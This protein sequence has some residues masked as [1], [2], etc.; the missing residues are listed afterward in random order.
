LSETELES[1]LLEEAQDGALGPGEVADLSLVD[2][3]PPPTP[4]M[5]LAFYEE[6]MGA[7]EPP[8]P[9]AD[10]PTPTLEET[11]EELAVE[12][13]A[14]FSEPPPPEVSD[15]ADGIL[16]P[17][18]SAMYMEWDVD[19]VLD[20]ADIQEPETVVERLELPERS[21]TQ[22]EQEKLLRRFGSA[23]LQELD[24]EISR[25]YDQVLSRVGENQEISTECH[26]LL[27][28]A[29][30]VVFRRDASRI[31]QAEF[32]VEQVRA[33]LKRAAE[34]EAGARKFA[35]LITA[36]GLVWGA[37]F[38]AL[39]ILLNHEWF[40]SAVAPVAT[41]GLLA[42]TATFLRAM[43]WGGIG[44]VVAVLYSLFKHVGRRDFDTQYNLSYVGKPFLGL[45]LGATVY[46]VF[47]LLLTLQLLPAGLS[48]GAGP[49]GS[50]TPWVIYPL[51][52]A[53]GFKENRIFDLV[54][55]VIKR[56]F[57]G[58]EKEQGAPPPEFPVR[59]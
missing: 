39:L 59:S 3:L 21:L 10:A 1:A 37:G 35:W 47:Q 31:P 16:P 36:W 49:A 27:L 8:V 51:A 55:R 45:I 42:D 2:D 24:K 58:K 53:C 40:I 18:P 17:R 5:E 23:R 56:L 30:D 41:S 29:R 19:G 7:A 26:N 20:T 33:R 15:L 57:S 54:D 50:V 6:A 43:I 12:E 52:W 46:M 48:T 44:G 4:E 9:V 28:K 25:V 34:S 38:L 32:Y 22:A 11:M 13:E 14:T